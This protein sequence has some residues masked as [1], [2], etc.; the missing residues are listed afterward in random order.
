VRLSSRARFSF[1]AI[2]AAIS[3]Q[4]VGAVPLSVSDSMTFTTLDQGLW[5]PGTAPLVEK[6]FT[7]KVVD[8]DTGPISIGG[9]DTLSTSI[10]NP[11]Y[12]AWSAAYNSCRLAY[13]HSTC[14]NGATINL[15][16]TKIKIPG[17][18]SPPPTRLPVDLGKNG[19]EI[20]AD[21]DVEAGFKG[22]LVVDSGKVDVTY[23][24]TVTLSTDRDSYRAGELVTLRTSETVTVAPTMSTEFSDIDVSLSVFANLDVFTAVEAYLVDKGGAVTVFDVDRNLEYELLG[25]S[26]GNSEIGLRLYELDPFVLDTTGGLGLNLFKLKYP[27]C[28]DGAGAAQ[29]CTPLSL[30]PLADFQLQVPDL[31]TAPPTDSTWDGT[32]ITNTQL[33]IERSAAN[34]DD[35]TLIGGGVGFH[36][37]DLAKADIDVDGIISAASISAGAPIVLGVN[38]SIPLVVSLE[39]NLIDFDLGA[40]FG[41]G[42]TMTFDPELKSLLSF[43]VPLEVET[44]PGVYEAMTSLT[45]VV[46]DEVKFRHP[47]V[48]F[49]IVP[50][51]SLENL[52]Q[53]ITELLISPVASLSVAQLKLGGILPGVLGIG[54]DAALYQNVFAL[55][56]P[57][58]AARLGD[59]D[60]FEL[61]GFASFG[62]SALLLRTAAAS[63]PE[64]ATPALLLAVALSLLVVRV[65]ASRPDGR[66]ALRSDGVHRQTRLQR[67]HNCGF[68]DAYPPSHQSNV[69]RIAIRVG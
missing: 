18:G 15:G 23:P 45:I 29:S 31:D 66:S 11:A 51:Y 21:I 62:G 27:P 59:S 47:G 68:F 12:L 4:Q 33:P 35:L 17:V 50:T 56:D 14:I 32:K 28:V 26:V 65:A 5:G 39:A 53:N 37:T 58:S 55:S 44:S 46:G 3:G 9:I 2:C 52:F 64:P 7:L 6:G 25:L 24:T 1:I 22:K 63:A 38:P 8:V 60:P 54:F 30:I 13:S 57:I 69:L 19:L 20:S 43:S 48:D 10:P 36:R 16:F 40:F 41:I 49:E 34:P 42:Q 61:A 67:R